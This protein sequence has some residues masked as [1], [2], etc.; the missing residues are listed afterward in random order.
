MDVAINFFK[1]CSPNQRIRIH[2][3]DVQM[4]RVYVQNIHEKSR[5]IFYSV[6]MT[7]YC[8]HVTSSD[9]IFANSLS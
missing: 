5:V 7:F 3:T 2:N 1:C 4:Y 9:S 6:Q 8:Q